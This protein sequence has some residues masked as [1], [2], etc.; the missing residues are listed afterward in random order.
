MSR[1]PGYLVKTKNGK[2]AIA[3]HK[4]GMING[5]QQVTVLDDEMKPTGEKLLINPETA[6]VIGMVD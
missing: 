5:K 3:Y 1:N 2:K 6:T 4:D